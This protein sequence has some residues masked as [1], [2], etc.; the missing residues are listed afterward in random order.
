MEDNKI[1]KLDHKKKETEEVIE[2][3]ELQP[4]IKHEKKTKKVNTLST[5][6]LHMVKLHAELIKSKASS[7]DKVPAKLRSEIEKILG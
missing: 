7:L 5:H 1:V 6:D 3:Q 2:A 4:E